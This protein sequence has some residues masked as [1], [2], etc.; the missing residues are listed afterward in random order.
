MNTEKVSIPKEKISEFCQRWEIIE[1]SLFGSILRDDFNEQSDIDILVTFAE[2]AEIGLFE[3]AQI[4]IELE[5]LYDRPV[6]VIEKASLRN[7]YRRKEIL[8][9]AEVFYAH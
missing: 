1:F 8:N 6:D 9:T 3:I 7:P 5:E 4:K 2:D